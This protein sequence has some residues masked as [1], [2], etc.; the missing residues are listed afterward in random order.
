[1]YKTNGLNFIRFDGF[2]S[3]VLGW[4]LDNDFFDDALAP[5]KFF[6]ALLVFQYSLVALGKSY[7]HF[8][9]PPEALWRRPPVALGFPWI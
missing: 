3:W 1:M 6:L 4:R 7:R 8:V 2:F 5:G 9:V